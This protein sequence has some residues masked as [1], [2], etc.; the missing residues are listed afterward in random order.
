LDKIINV[1]LRLTTLQKLLVLVGVVV[2]IGGAYGYFGY[3]SKYSRIEQL[4][5]K[6]ANLQQELKKKKDISDKYLEYK[7]NMELIKRKLEMALKKLPT[8]EEMPSLLSA[9][10]ADGNRVGLEFLLFKPQPEVKLD[11]YA[12]IPIEMRVVGTFHEVA[13]FF[14]AVAD[15]DRIVNIRSFDMGQPK[16]EEGRTVTITTCSA[17]T[18]RYFTPEERKQIEEARKA[19]EAAAAPKRPPAPVAPIRRR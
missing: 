12:E 5:P 10:S 1:V 14:D 18:F 19:K 11:F 9:I 17:A 8:S 16:D 6:L 7:A 15:L 4:R 3:M 2:I 13:M